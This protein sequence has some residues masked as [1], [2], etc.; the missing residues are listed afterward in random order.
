MSEKPLSQHGRARIKDNLIQGY[1]LRNQIVHGDIV[2]IDGVWD[3]Y[4]IIEDY[5]RKSL[6]QLLI[7]RK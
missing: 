4:P 7:N 3:I 5:L 1:R 6:Y 2:D